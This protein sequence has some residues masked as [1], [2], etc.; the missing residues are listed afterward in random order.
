MLSG[1]FVPD[2][3]YTLGVTLNIGCLA[4]GPPPD[5]FFI[6]RNDEI[7]DERFDQLHY[8]TQTS[9]H[10]IQYV[11]PSLSPDDFGVYICTYV[12]PVFSG[13]SRS[14]SI[15]IGGMRFSVSFVIYYL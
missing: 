4:N 3:N 14:N 8:D 2:A 15:S 1:P 11:I 10:L 13:G 5:R 7:I 9:Q 6:T 12:T